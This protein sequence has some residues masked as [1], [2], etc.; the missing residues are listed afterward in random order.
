MP[1][2][3]RGSQ[4]KL[5]LRVRSGDSLGR[6]MKTMLLSRNATLRR[7]NCVVA[8]AIQQNTQKVPV[9]F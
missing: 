4:D 7:S 5:A 2:E 3:A 8:D 1:V 6:T 9:F